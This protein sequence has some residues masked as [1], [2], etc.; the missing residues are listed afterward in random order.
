MK[1]TLFAQL[2]LILITGTLVGCKPAGAETIYIGEQDA[3]KTVELKTGD[4]LVVSLDGNIT[5]GFNWIPASQDPA[6]LEP[7]GDLEVTPANEE[8]GAPGKIVFQFKAIAEG[9]TFLHL[10]YKRPWEESVAPERTF[11]VNVVVK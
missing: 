7:V 4:T 5:T 11:E 6:L 8:L 2:I 9:Q 3:G 1:T 10:D